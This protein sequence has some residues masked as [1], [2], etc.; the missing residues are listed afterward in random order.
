MGK[1]WIL[2]LVAGMVALPALPLD[3]IFTLENDTF[4]RKDDSDY[5]HGTGLS[6]VDG[7]MHYMVQ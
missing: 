2:M 7:R 5:T 4:L 3:T 1:T 6:A